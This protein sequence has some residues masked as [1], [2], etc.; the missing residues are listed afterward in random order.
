MSIVIDETKDDLLWDKL[1]ETQ[2][3][4][5]HSRAKDIAS[6]VRAIGVSH[7]AFTVGA[8]IIYGADNWRMRISD[9]PGDFAET[10]LLL[11]EE[12]KNLDNAC[13]WAILGHAE[14]VS[15]DYIIETIRA[16]PSIEPIVSL[17]LSKNYSL[18]VIRS[19]IES[20][21]DEALLESLEATS[22]R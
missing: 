2:L 4:T 7:R 12:T 16:N 14:K 8:I 1:L 20:D 22:G 9:L 19:I 3:R 5:I 21:V 6:R 15:N 13:M 10:I 18:E 17:R 11:N